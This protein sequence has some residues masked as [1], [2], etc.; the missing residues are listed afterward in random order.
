MEFRTGRR[1]QA[2]PMARQAW[3]THREH[4]SVPMLRLIVWLALR[5]GR[6]PARLLLYPL[7][8]YF[9]AFAAGS[10]AASRDYLGRVLAGRPGLAEQWRHFFTFGACVL[11]RVFLLNDRTD[12]FDISVHGGE[13][14]RAL[15]QPGAGCLLFGAH[16]GSFEVL[17]T[18]ARREPDLR[19]SLLMYQANARKTNTVLQAINPALDVEVIPLGES[20]S[21]LAVAARLAEGHVVGL[22][23]DRGLDAKTMLAM[24]FLGAPARFPVGPFRMVALLRRPVVLMLGLY[25]GG[26]R[27]DIVFE[28]IVT[29]EEFAD[30]QTGPTIEQMMQRYVE[31]LAFHCQQAPYNWFNF[32]RFWG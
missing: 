17:R 31:R 4:G 16:L 26:N 14:V 2:P 24:P 3:A 15:V 18:M 23:A 32:Y 30:G 20:G 11:D 5:L 22:L 13:I 27:Y 6:A 8:G 1:G 29:A 10:R 25:R 19:V 21:M 9:F 12:L 7:C 28:Q